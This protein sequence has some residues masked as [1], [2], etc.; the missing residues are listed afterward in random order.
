MDPA[1]LMAFMSMAGQ[2]AS[3]VS[4]TRKV[5]GIPTP[6]S[7][8]ESGLDYRGFMDEAFPGTTPWE[9]LGASTGGQPAAT[10]TAGSAQSMQN[11]EFQQQKK[12]TEMNNRASIIGSSSLGGA[13]EA[14]SKLM[15]Y[16]FG[17]G[18]PYDTQVKQQREILPKKIVQAE[19]DIK[20]TRRDTESRDIR[21]RLDRMD[22]R[23]RQED[24]K[25]TRLRGGMRA[26][27]Q[28]VGSIVPGAALYRFASNTGFKPR[29]L[30]TSADLGYSGSASGSSGYASNYG[31]AKR[32][33]EYY[34]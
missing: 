1:T 22:E 2:T 6:T 10:L 14:Q 13:E 15:S 29:R 11:R 23:D 9:R 18:S 17:V 7:G 33:R 20:N 4:N 24:M 32:S 21:N 28:G 16:M 3:A 25:Y 19:E 27:G 5:P 31:R 26:F 30:T 34:S 8:S 12:I